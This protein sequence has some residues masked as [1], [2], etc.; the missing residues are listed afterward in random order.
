MSAGREGKKVDGKCLS[1]TAS[2]IRL[3]HKE[4]KTVPVCAFYEVMI[5]WCKC[6][7]CTDKL[8][9]HDDTEVQCFFIFLPWRD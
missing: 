7:Y 2:Y 9:N 6:L 3:R 5:L 8:K 4:D 1:L